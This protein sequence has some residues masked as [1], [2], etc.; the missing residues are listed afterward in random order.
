MH[1]IICTKPIYLYATYPDAIHHKPLPFGPQICA[2]PSFFLSLVAAL[3]SLC[4]YRVFAMQHIQ[5]VYAAYTCVES[6]CVCVFYVDAFCYT[7]VAVL[8]AQSALLSNTNRHTH[9]IAVHLLVFV[10]TDA[11]ELYIYPLPK[12]IPLAHTHAVHNMQTEWFRTRKNHHSHNIL[13]A[14]NAPK[15]KAHTQKGRSTARDQHTTIYITPKK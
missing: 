8:C 15:C 4:K 5:L 7:A 9:T 12:C 14:F 11:T 13:A 6:F 3:W 10:W 1:I 2:C